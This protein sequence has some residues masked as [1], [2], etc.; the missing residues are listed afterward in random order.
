[1][2]RVFV[3]A[4]IATFSV[5][6]LLCALQCALHPDMRVDWAQGW[7]RLLAPGGELLTMV[8]P[9]DPGMDAGS[10]PPWAVTPELY[11]ELL[12]PA[13]GQAVQWIL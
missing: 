4:T 5:C 8:Y 11:K 9:V 10:G 6:V 12:L 2:T 1:M 7:G 13:G 3:C